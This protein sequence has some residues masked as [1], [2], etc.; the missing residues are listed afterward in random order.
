MSQARNLALAGLLAATGSISSGCAHMFNRYDVYTSTFLDETESETTDRQ[1]G[2]RLNL[3]SAFSFGAMSRARTVNQAAGMNALG[4]ALQTESVRRGSRGP[5]YPIAIEI[6]CYVSGKDI[7]AN[8]VFERSEMHGLGSTFSRD[9]P[10]RVY[11]S[12]SE[13][14]REL[15]CWVTKGGKTIDHKKIRNEDSISF[16]YNN[17]FWSRKLTPGDYEVVANLRGN[18]VGSKKFKVN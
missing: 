4:H 8:G 14:S 9:E 7:N 10:I 5:G 17:G 18:W 15:D 2:N 6:G 1:I 11:V 16:V 12:L 3:L 13:P